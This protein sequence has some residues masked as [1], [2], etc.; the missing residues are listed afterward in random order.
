MPKKPGGYN[1]SHIPK[2]LEHLTSL[3]NPHPSQELPV[4]YQRDHAEGICA[5]I[6]RLEEPGASGLGAHKPQ[7]RQ[8]QPE[9]PTHLHWYPEYP[10]PV[11]PPTGKKHGQWN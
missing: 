5:M 6:S 1:R 10:L 11:K 2:A 3:P 9:A 8:P 7:P 4:P